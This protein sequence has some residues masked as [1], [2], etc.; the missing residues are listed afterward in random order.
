MS[1]N[2]NHQ[3]SSTNQVNCCLL[4]NCLERM[5]EVE[6]KSIN[7]IL[8]DLPYGKTILEWDKILNFKELWS[9]F[10]KI[11]H[12]DGVI[13]TTST[14]PFTSLTINS[15]LDWF[16][17]ELIWLKNKSGNGFLVNRRHIKIHE[18]IIVFSP[19]KKYT[20]NAEK[21]LVDKKEFLTQRKTFNEYTRENNIYGKITKERTDDTGNE[22][23]PLSIVS[24]RIPFTTQNSK[25]Y[26][27]KIDIRLHP[28]QKP[29][30]LFEYLIKT[31][32]NEGDKVLDCCAGS[33]TTAIACMNTNRKY[34]CIEK[35][36]KYFK[37]MQERINQRMKQLEVFS[38]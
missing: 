8:T 24:C 25:Q 33:G 2:T 31:Y 16:K 19:F 3:K 34:I 21:W 12:D 26:D 6:D 23:F 1:K 37:T 38:K 36:E 10:E 32:S 11:L 18:N 14:Q 15:K 20:F 30:E 9:C 22:R 4:G 13:I 17:E 29:L 5:K 28:T 35:D 7:L 27:K